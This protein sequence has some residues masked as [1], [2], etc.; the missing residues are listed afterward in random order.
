[1]KA[2]ELL[3]LIVITTMAV[4]CNSKKTRPTEKHS[5]ENTRKTDYPPPSENAA[6]VQI[7][8]VAISPRPLAAE[9]FNLDE[10]YQSLRTSQDYNFKNQIPPSSGQSRNNRTTATSLDND[11]NSF[12]LQS[13]ERTTHRQQS[14]KNS[15]S[16]I[17]RH[18]NCEPRE[19]STVS[20]CRRI[21][22]VGKEEVKTSNLQEKR[23]A[24]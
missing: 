5:I 1:M 16:N 8:E 14:F 21:H 24:Y 20:T 18:K 11:T 3:L 23:E 6:E 9:S 17:K 22:R 13:P 10:N 7:E 4:S 15:Q 12:E 2:V 19:I